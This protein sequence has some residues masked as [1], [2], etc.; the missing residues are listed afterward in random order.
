MQLGLLTSLELPYLLTFPLKYP[1]T[2]GYK[3]IQPDVNDYIPDRFF[4]LLHLCSVGH[5]KHLLIAG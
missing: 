4:P 1:C 3:R 2:N 5:E